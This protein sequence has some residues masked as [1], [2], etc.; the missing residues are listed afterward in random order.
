MPEMP[1]HLHDLLKLCFERVSDARPVNMLELS[2]PL[3]RIYEKKFSE[4]GRSASPPTKL[5]IPPP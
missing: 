1:K 5:S 4:Y 2:I 3:E